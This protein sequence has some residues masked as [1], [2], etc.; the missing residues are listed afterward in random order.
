M[1]GVGGWLEVVAAE[2]PEEDVGSVTRAAE[3]RLG[4]CLLRAIFKSKYPKRSSSTGMGLGAAGRGWPGPAVHAGRTGRLPA[5]C[6][7]TS[8]CAPMMTVRSRGRLK[9]SAAS[10][11]M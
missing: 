1:Y 5:L 6:A 2:H 3:D 7:Y 8:M 11:V 9:Y 10:D 4:W